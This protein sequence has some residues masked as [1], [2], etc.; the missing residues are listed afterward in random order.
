MSKFF[1]GQKLTMIYISP[2]LI[3]ILPKRDICVFQTNDGKIDIWKNTTENNRQRL[4]LVREKRIMGMYALW[5]HPI[6]EVRNV[7]EDFRGITISNLHGGTVLAEGWEVRMNGGA[8][9]LEVL[10]Q[11]VFDRE[12]FWYRD[13]PLLEHVG[14]K[15]DRRAIEALA[16]K[17]GHTRIWG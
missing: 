2:D 13:L 6:K 16:E 9:I 8:G 3:A 4:A 12:R 17:S 10:K 15:V 5:H 7:T 11:A 14:L 1:P